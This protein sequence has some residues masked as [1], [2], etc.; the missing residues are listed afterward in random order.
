MSICRGE[1]LQSSSSA[2]LTV[3]LRCFEVPFRSFDLVLDSFIWNQ[4]GNLPAVQLMFK[5]LDGWPPNSHMAE[6]SSENSQ[7]CVQGFK[8]L[9]E[10][11]PHPQHM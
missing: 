11:Q 7:S 10:V 5:D 1:Q 8:S 9:H 6:T 4:L 2:A 3:A